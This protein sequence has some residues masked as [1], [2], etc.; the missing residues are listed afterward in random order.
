[1]TSF[2]RIVIFTFLFLL[3][4]PLCGQVVINEFS[5]SN[6]SASANNYG[7]YDDWIELYNAGSAAVNLAG[8][9]LSDDDTN[10]TKWQ[11]PAGVSISAGGFLKIW[12]SGRDELS[13][14][15]IHTNFKLGQKKPN[16]EF[17]VFADAGATVLESYNLFDYT[18]QNNHSYGRTTNGAATWAVFTSPTPGASNNAAASYLKYADK[19]VFSINSGFYTG[20][21]SVSITTTEPNAVIRYTT[22]GDE[23]TTS[24]T[25]YSAPI[26][27]SS[28]T[29]I[30]AKVFSNNA[31]ILPGFYDFN[32]YFFNANHSVPVVSIAGTSV[33]DLLNGSYNS[34]KGCIEYFE[35]GASK[36]KVTGEFNKHGN[37]S[38]AYNQ[39]GFDFISRDEFGY[40]D[41]LHYKIF[42]SSPRKNFQRLIF[43]PAANDNY[44]FEDGA[45]IRD[46]YVHMLSQ[47]GNM[48]LDERI[49][50][51]CV[52]YLNGQYW[53]VYE[54]REKADDHDYTSYYYD[55]DKL[56][57]Y[58]LKTWGGTWSEYGGN[59]A[60]NDWDALRNY[61]MNNNMGIP[62]NYAYV[63]NRLNL[64][65]LIDYFIINTHTVCKDWLN[66]NTAWWRGTDSAGQQLKWRYTLWDMDAT[67]GHYINYTGIPEIGPTADPCY[68]ENLPNPGGQGHTDIM[69]K[70]I[71]ESPA[72]KQ[73]YLNRYN[74]LLNGILQCDTMLAI[75]DEY[76]NRIQPEM[77]AQI[78][79]WGGNYA[80]WQ[81][82]VQ[83]LKD[84]ILQRCAYIN[85]GLVDCYNISGP[86]NVMFNVNPA[87]GGTI[88]LNANPLA[89]YPSTKQFMGGVL[90]NLEAI[91]A[92]GY[93]FDHWEILH[94][95][96][97]PNNLSA[98]VTVT[99][100][101]TDTV[102]AHFVQLANP[103]TI[104]YQVEPAGAGSISVN[105]IIPASYPW[106]AT[107]ADGDNVNVA[108]TANINY[109]F[110][111]WTLLN[112]TIL[113][114]TANPAGSFTVA[115][116]DSVI[117]WFTPVQQPETLHLAIS[118]E[119]PYAG[120]VLLNNTTTI[121]F[122]Y[123]ENY[124]TPTQITLKESPKNNYVFS[125]WEVDNH[126]L[127]PDNLSADV[128]FMMTQD[129][130]VIAYFNEQEVSVFLP[131][132]FSPNE[133]GLNDVFAVKGHSKLDY[134]EIYL[135]NRW[136][137]LIF[138]SS[139]TDFSWD[140]TFKGQLCPVDAYSYLFIYSLEGSDSKHYAYGSVVLLR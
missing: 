124:T 94:D 63:G 32:T 85:Q 49:Y 83:D 19:P 138:R 51:P 107:Y 111:H 97:N 24:S 116:N 20:S 75:L 44:P 110:S 40:G 128:S 11:F 125:H 29:V 104:V 45:H 46:A 93:I 123:S 99:F 2:N 100:D 92:T 77:Q 78:N 95:T 10:P 62:A 12:A 26:N 47:R 135:Y 58:Y 50:E 120:Y 16:P 131:T 103:R 81:N 64:L 25:A 122:N 82:N 59:A 43:K 98:A 8:Y 101:G 73:L 27:V 14:G 48:E 87:G 21:V 119:P 9:Y 57:L 133:D 106:S 109:A 13:G 28:T 5:C 22:N 38:W 115:S 52:L 89:S 129:E 72:F 37:D 31:Q 117:A 53:G 113:P 127:I 84:F 102:I 74:Q 76:I 90:N 108:A 56:D 69:K 30:M 91:P 126:V 121:D 105:G 7:D 35:G 1:M 86:Y 68:G 79:K 23:P 55:Q 137:Q 4:Q 66:W 140:G 114:G 80:T 88:K 17:I 6:L 61:V 65:S 71:D 139:A 67:F 70:L 96:L 18:T 41:A 118:V 130:H 34:P 136:G 54:T 60:Q 112:H 36:T 33:S 42:S 15:N 132:S 39:R 134:C 3:I